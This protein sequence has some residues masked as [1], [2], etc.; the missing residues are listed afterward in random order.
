MGGRGL[1]VKPA[2]K[3]A[4]LGRDVTE[5]VKKRDQPSTLRELG[6]VEDWAEFLVICS[7]RNY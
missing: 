2:M 3:S 5:V 1:A 6:E 7:E 4:T